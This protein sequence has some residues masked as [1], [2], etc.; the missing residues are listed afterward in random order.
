MIALGHIGDALRRELLTHGVTPRE[1][2]RLDAPNDSGAAPPVADLQTPLDGTGSL[3]SRR[4]AVGIGAAGNF[5][6]GT[7]RR[8][9]RP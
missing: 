4:S 9:E 2:A 3:V 7:R 6:R 5:H 8:S 1:I